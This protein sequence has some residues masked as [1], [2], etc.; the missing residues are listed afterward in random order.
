MEQ[1]AAGAGPGPPGIHEERTKVT[2]T[3]L[4]KP[5]APELAARSRQADR[6]DTA[7]P[8]TPREREILREL[9]RHQTVQDIADGLRLS[10]N[11]VK[12]HLKSLYQKLGV[13]RRS[14]AVKRG[15]EIGL[16]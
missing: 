4:S 12:T 16:L 2:E 13:S 14:A 15:A 7:R 1:R 5:A 3:G 9:P 8:L 11:T 10:P 6:P